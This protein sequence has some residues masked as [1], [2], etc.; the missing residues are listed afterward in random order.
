MIYIGNAQWIKEDTISS[1]SYR[2]DDYKKEHYLS[3]RTI[4]GYTHIS[5]LT[6]TETKD[7]YERLKVLK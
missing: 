7:L 3:I 2:Y 4:D 5:E 1:I 6:D